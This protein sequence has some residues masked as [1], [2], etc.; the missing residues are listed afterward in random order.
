MTRNYTSVFLAEETS[1]GYHTFDVHDISADVVI[2]RIAKSDIYNKNLYQAYCQCAIYFVYNCSSYMPI[3]PLQAI[4][5][6]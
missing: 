5:P 2:C 1:P 6:F 3:Q 4:I